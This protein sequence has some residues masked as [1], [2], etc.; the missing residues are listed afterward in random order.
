MSQVREHGP[1]QWSVVWMVGG[2][3]ILALLISTSTNDQTSIAWHVGV[4]IVIVGC[5]ILWSLS[6]PVK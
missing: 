5:L 3:V 1:K 6:Q 4:T 2:I